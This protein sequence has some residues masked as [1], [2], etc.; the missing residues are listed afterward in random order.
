[1]QT[2]VN[3]PE[4]IS[5]AISQILTQ[6]QN[7]DWIKKA[8][9][10][11]E[12]YMVGKKEINDSFIQDFSDALAYLALRTPATYAQ[13]HSALLSILELVPSW[14]PK[15]L[16]DIGSGPGTGVWAASSLFSGLE[17]AT[18]IE[19]DKNFISLGKQIL[20]NSKFQVPI[21]WR[22]QDIRYGI[23]GT[24]YYDVIIIANVLNELSVSE[25]EKLIGHALNA[26]KGILLI[27][28]PGT[29]FGGSIVNSAAKK[30]HHAGVLLAPY[31]KNSFV[32]ND[33]YYLH[34]P[35]R[36]I[37]PEFQKRIRQRARDDSLASS[38]WEEAKYSYVA[39]SKFPSEVSLFGRCVGQAKL[40]KG[41]LEIPILTKEEI[42]NQKVLKRY[43]KQYTYAKNLKWGELLMH[44]EDIV[45]SLVQCYYYAL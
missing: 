13:I 43:K 9:E 26:C 15:T 35:Q 11:H 34:F 37:R 20:S 32:Q 19:Q 18:C 8:L 38:N 22:Q 17:S 40:Q 33:S 10:L 39:I 30:L 24:S 4:N 44:K 16:L 6:Q 14:K 5:H 2:F 25:G 1:M 27:L 21:S 41:F 28:E 3:L 12:R 7:A 23:E 42:I 31:I 29:P 45:Y 36:F